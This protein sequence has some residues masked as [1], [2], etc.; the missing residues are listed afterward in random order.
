MNPEIVVLSPIPRSLAEA[1]E[2]SYPTHHEWRGEPVP[3]EAAGRILGMVTSGTKGADSAQLARFP[4]LGICAC[5]G[6]GVDAIDLDAA[7]SLGIAVTN[8]PD[9]LTDDV[10]DL[11]IGLALSVLR[12]ICVGD[13]FIRSGAWAAGQA[14]AETGFGR[15]L[16]GRR[17][18]IL[19]LGRIGKAVAHRAKA[20]GMEIAWHGPHPK[21]GIPW[22]RH[23]DPASLAAWSE[24]LV[25]ACPGGDATQGLVDAG[26][27]EALGPDGILVNVARGS[28]VDEPALVDA[29]VSGRLG[30]AG[31]DVF[32][33]EPDVPESLLPLDNVVLTPHRGSATTE[34]R[35]AMAR[36][37][38]GNL[39]AFFAG[40]PLPTP[41]G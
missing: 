11:A 36:L 2:A 25:V 37:V 28:V 18:G 29:L 35:D 15:A 27:I 4:N 32:R 23:P 17:L 34:T 5:F 20:F 33:D 3:P 31:L 1:L 26:V 22:L 9:V 24:V 21:P 30:G 40:R 38:L 6:V 10:A 12:R 7:R 19:G 16:S 41:V 13:R 14:A 8:T 39:R